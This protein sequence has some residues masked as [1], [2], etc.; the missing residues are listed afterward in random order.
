MNK[1]LI[2]ATTGLVCAPVLLPAK[3]AKAQKEDASR[4]NILLILCDDM[5]YGDLACYGQP[6]IST[7]NIDRVAE[8]GIRFTQAYAGSPVSAPSRATIM[9]G[10][11]SGHSHVRGNK[12]YWSYDNTMKY[13]DNVDFAVVGQEPYD[14]AHKILPEI[15][16]DR[17]YRT[18]VFGKWA[19]GYEG[20]A[21][22][23]DKR[24]V[25]EFYG[26]ICQFQAH[27]YYPNFLNRFSRALGDTAVVREVME[28]NMKY[29]MFGRKY[30]KRTQYSARIIHDKALEW[31]D[32]QDTQHP[33][34]GFFTYTL[35]HAELAQPDDDIL[36]S[37]KKKFFVDKTW[38]GQESSRYNPVEHT[39][40][41]FAGMITRLDAY[42]GEIMA[43]LKEKGL[44]KNTIVI[45][46]SD[47]GPHE[48]GG[49]D[50]EYFGRDGKLRGL[51]RQCYEGG[52]RIPFI[53]WWPGHIKAGT[54]S[55]LPFAFYDLMPTFCDIAGVKNFR[56][57][58]TNRSLPGDCFDGLS[59]AP[60]LLG[61]NTKQQ[62]HEHLYWE[63]HE[64]DQ[65]AVRRGD[66]KLIVVKGI[67]RLYNLATDLHEDKDIAAEHPEIVRELFD[68]IRK[69]H[70][71][72]PMFKVTLPY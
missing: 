55:D 16:K 48:E 20:S 8:E 51:K 9:T 17:G 25:D 4:P 65:I 61:D 60:T 53:A 12:E 6:F 33:F 38:G 18:G 54:V 11:H 31:I 68:I 64:T 59:I 32:K 50:P 47:N 22:T 70:T 66:W 30:F 28:D 45:F 37:Y 10:Q 23:P 44:D 27:L 58:Y 21:S 15:L 3:S 35:P 52:I 19:G 26:Y 57:R 69:E 43:K 5:G 71:D 41:Q 13:G 40:A 49:A 62:R 67:P 1:K 29:P 63:F 56:K 2:L 42:V 72:N 14:P 7:P 36:E 39:H 34:V 46:T 24:G